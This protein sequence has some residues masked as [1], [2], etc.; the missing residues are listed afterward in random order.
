[1][2]RTTITLDP[3]VA[4]LVDLRMAG[5][6]K[7]F[8]QVVNEGLRRGL[9]V[10]IAESPPPYRLQTFDSPLEAGVDLAKVNQLLDEEPELRIG[11]TP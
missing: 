3:D 10:G 2:M 4:R 11:S 9:A 5:E 7:G 1:M 6:G 8:Q